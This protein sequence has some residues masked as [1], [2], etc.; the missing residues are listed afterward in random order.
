MRRRV[1][2]TDH[3]WP[4]LEIE[5]SVLA[6]VE[7]LEPAS[8][9]EAELV[10][11]AGGVDAILTNWR[12][13]PAEA[14]EAAPGCLVVSRYGV[15][16]DNIPVERATALGIL[17]VNVPDFC[18]D[19]VSDHAMAFVLACSRRLVSLARGP[20]GHELA[21]GT[22]RLRGQTLGLV[23]FGQI[24]RRIVP[25]AQGFGLRVLAWSRSIAD[26][27]ASGVEGTREL[28]RL[29]AE[30]DFVSLHLPATPDTQ[31]LIGEAE[32]RAM[33]STAYLINTSRGSLVDE[34]ALERALREGWIAGAALD[35]LTQEPP[36]IGHPLLGLEN[37]IVTPHAAFYSEDAVTELATRAASNVATVLEGRIPTNVVNPAVLDAANLRVRG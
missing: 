6:G 31:G 28:V 24:A 33:K 8:G 30:S 4:T 15:G 2:V 11:L 21:R 19:E 18:L 12:K 32:L 23:G 14:L 10:E 7:L 9:A 17:V 36:P 35:V 16:V 5:R 34:A 29:L 1:L 25:K 37:C 27:P 22:A 20:W 26:A 13:L 3:A